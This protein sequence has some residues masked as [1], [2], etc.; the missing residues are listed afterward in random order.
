MSPRIATTERRS[1]HRLTEWSTGRR[2]HE[3]GRMVRLGRRP[4]PVLDFAR[5]VVRSLSDRPR[6][7]PSRFLYDAEGRRIFE[8]M[9]RAPEYYLTRVE[10][11][12]LDVCAPSICR[13]TGPRTI[14]ELGSGGPRKADVLLAAY[15]EAYGPVRYAPVDESE[16]ALSAT[17]HSLTA[18]HQ[19]LAIR[20]LLGLSEAAFPLFERFSPLL[21]LFLGSALGNL[22]ETEAAAFWTRVSRALAPRDCVL[23]GVDLVKDPAAIHAAYNDAAGWSAAF[24]R[25]AFARMN[26]ELGSAVDLDGLRH[27]AAYRSEWRRVEIAARITRPQIIRVAPLGR[28]VTLQTGERVRVGISRKFEVADL[29]SYLSAFG[30]EP[31][32]TFADTG[33]GYALLLLRRQAG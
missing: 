12:L 15:G 26:R 31:L 22:P 11:A 8:R 30:F 20:A 33:R 19:A 24:T 25:N 10:R 2:A 9:C 27:E 4:D 6:W 23:V 28:T 5:A 14:V 32:R 13:L 18:R 29:E 7:V 21:L 17:L 3:R 16:S 1:Q